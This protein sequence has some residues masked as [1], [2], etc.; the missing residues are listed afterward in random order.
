MTAGAWTP[1]TGNSLSSRL[2]TFKWRV[3]KRENTATV[4]SRDG[5]NKE[6]EP[7]GPVPYGRSTQR[8]TEG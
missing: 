6:N 5:K 1:S 2:L 4:G 3:S 7:V 8:T